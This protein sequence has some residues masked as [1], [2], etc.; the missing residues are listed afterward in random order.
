MINSTHHAEEAHSRSD[1][2]TI[3]ALQLAM[4]WA[5]LGWD[6]CPL[7]SSCRQAFFTL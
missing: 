7:S 2:D 6:L 5:C 4:C 1:K 3:R